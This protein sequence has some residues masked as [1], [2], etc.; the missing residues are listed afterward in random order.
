MQTLFSAIAI[1]GTFFF[2]ELI[3]SDIIPPVS[4]IPDFGKYLLGNMFLAVIA[5]FI[6]TTI[7]WIHEMDKDVKVPTLMKRVCFD[8]LKLISP[9]TL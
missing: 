3:V 9:T 5:M 4:T 1:F 6:S 8:M 7:C 2:L